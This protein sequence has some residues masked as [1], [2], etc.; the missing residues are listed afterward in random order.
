MAR[1]TR[2]KNL[3]K[4]MFTKDLNFGIF[5][6]TNGRIT[7]TYQIEWSRV[8]EI[9]D[10]DKFSDFQDNQLAYKRIRDSGLHSLA[11]RLAILPYNDAVKWIVERMDL[12]SC[13]LN[14]SRG[15]EIANFR[16]EVFTKA[17][18]LKLIRQPL[19]A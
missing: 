10:N 9:F 12:K 8:Y 3:E 11:A 15:L 6:N 14:D 13:C 16:P 19:T 18:A 1:S 17:Y 5:S 2:C 4:D 7:E